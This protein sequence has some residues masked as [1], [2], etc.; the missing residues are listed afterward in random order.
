[1]SEQTTIALGDFLTAGL[2]PEGRYRLEVLS[3]EV[4]ERSG[5]NGPYKQASFRVNLVERFGDG[6]IEN[7]ESEFINCSLSGKGVARL[8][9]LYVASRG[10]VPEGDPD[11]VL[12]IE[13][14]VEELIGSENI[15]AQYYW[16]RPKNNPDDV[17]GVLGWDY[18][19]DPDNLRDPKPFAERDAA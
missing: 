5:Q 18:S 1:M 17:E 14:L 15:W 11:T 13:D 16:R 2:Q 6:I 10:A 4:V 7:P 9:K 12:T 3:G 8:R 19:S